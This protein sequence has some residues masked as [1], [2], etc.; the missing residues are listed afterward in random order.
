MTPKSPRAVKPVTHE[1]YQSQYVILVRKRPGNAVFLI[2]EG[3]GDNAA[4]F[5]SEEAAHVAADD[6]PACR[7]WPFSVIESP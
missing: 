3:D 4:T 2:T 1:P 5:P 6:I 7:A